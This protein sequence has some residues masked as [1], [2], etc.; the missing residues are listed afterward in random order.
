MTNYIL[1]GL[2]LI[3]IFVIAYLVWSKYKNKNSI[4]TKRIEMGAFEIRILNG[5]LTVKPK[6]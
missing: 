4:S 5:E 1:A 6:K 2:F 3:Q